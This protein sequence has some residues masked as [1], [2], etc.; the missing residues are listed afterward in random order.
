VSEEEKR[1]EKKEAVAVC[2]TCSNE[3][4]V[5]DPAVRKKRKCPICGKY[6]VKLK[7]EITPPS[8]PVP[9]A[10]GAVVIVEETGE[11]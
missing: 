6:P 4:V 8:V 7:G 10:P 5:R 11:D 1:E 3:W 2:L 9:P